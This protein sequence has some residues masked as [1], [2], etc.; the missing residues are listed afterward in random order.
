MII[1]FK[2]KRQMID[3]DALLDATYRSDDLDL[4]KPPS[5]KVPIVNLKKLGFDKKIIPVYVSKP[6]TC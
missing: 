6:K 1:I 5:S 2:N 3:S 4:E